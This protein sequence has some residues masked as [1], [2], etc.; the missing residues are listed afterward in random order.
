M[1]KNTINLQKISLLLLLAP[2]AYGS[3]QSIEINNPSDVV[4]ADITSQLDFTSL[5]NQIRKTH[6]F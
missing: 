5:T 3:D 1:K 2:Y 4:S 6:S